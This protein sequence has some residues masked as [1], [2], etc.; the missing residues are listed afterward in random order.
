MSAVALLR[1]LYRRLRPAPD[2]WDDFLASVD[3]GSLGLQALDARDK[4]VLFKRNVRLV[5]LE[6]HAYCNRICSFCP[7]ATIDRRGV[8]TR[9]DAGV[10]ARVLDELASI[11]FTG[12]LRFARYSEPMADEHIFEMITAARRALP[13]ANIDVVTNGDYLKPETLP[14]LREAG[15]SVLR[16]S[17]YLRDGAPWTAA[18]AREEMERLGRRIGIA[19]SFHSDTRDTVG[20]TFPFQGLEVDAWSHDFDLIGYDR[21]ESLPALVDTDYVRRSPCSMV[22]SNFTVD[23]DGKVMPCCNLR[24][25]HPAHQ[26][27]VLGDLSRGESIFDVYASPAFAGWR[28]SLAGVGEKAFPCRSCKQKAVEGEALVRLDEALGRKL[29]ALGAA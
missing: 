28:K 20:A 18:A 2:R 14:R 8:K 10:F 3:R 5:E 16:I 29:R 1:R 11:G 7:N 27:F 6:P 26:G 24:S 25:D 4:R 15:L 12:V 19:P 13:S 17:V 9:M 22:F 23:F 21:G